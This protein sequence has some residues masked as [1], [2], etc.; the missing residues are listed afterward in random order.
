MKEKT[1]Y[2]GECLFFTDL[3]C[4]AEAV[5]GRHP[6]GKVVTSIDIPVCCIFKNY[7]LLTAH[8]FRLF[9][10]STDCQSIGDLKV[11]VSGSKGRTVATHRD[12]EFPPCAVRAAD[13]TC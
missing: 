6:N 7:N 8:L 3:C 10:A 2:L 1:D 5:S 9:Q 12:A 13:A 11:L 4:P